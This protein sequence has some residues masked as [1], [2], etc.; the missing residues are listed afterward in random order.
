MRQ[1]TFLLLLFALVCVN[2]ALTFWGY[3]EYVCGLYLDRNA[4]IFIGT[5]SAVFCMA[6]MYG[7]YKDNVFGEYYVS[8]AAVFITP[9]LQ[10]V[11]LSAIIFGVHVSIFR[12]LLFYGTLSVAVNLVIGYKATNARDEK[13]EEAEVQSF[14]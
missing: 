6:F 8:N 9:V 11:I 1:K 5:V 10:G 3:G 14:G 13:A 7:T 2:Y 12:W 4:L